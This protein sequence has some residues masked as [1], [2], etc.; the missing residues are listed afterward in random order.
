MVKF[1]VTIEKFNIYHKLW[2]ISYENI[3]I[4]IPWKRCTKNGS[5]SNCEWIDWQWK[6]LFLELRYYYV[7]DSLSFTSPDCAGDLVSTKFI[8]A[9]LLDIYIDTYHIWI[10]LVMVMSYFDRFSLDSHLLLKKVEIEFGVTSINSDWFRDKWLLNCYT[11]SN[12]K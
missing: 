12:H 6:W 11:V 7:I 10:I 2:F 8:Q 1:N 5:F 4:P 3:W 9:W